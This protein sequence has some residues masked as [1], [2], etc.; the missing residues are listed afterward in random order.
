LTRKHNAVRH[1]SIVFDAIDGAF[2]NASKVRCDAVCH[3]G[4]VQLYTSCEEF[5]L[6]RSYSFY[7]GFCNQ[8]LVQT[9]RNFSHLRR[10]QIQS[11]IHRNGDDASDEDAQKM[12]RAAESG[13]ESSLSR[14]ALQQGLEGP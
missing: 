14:K 4:M 9:A 13:K 2:D 3:L 10:P 8:R 6:D 12:P 1:A 7:E 5:A 11:L